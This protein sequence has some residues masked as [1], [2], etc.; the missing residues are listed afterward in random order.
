MPYTILIAESI[1]LFTGLNT[2]DMEY[3]IK[4]MIAK[5]QKVELLVELT[6]K[7]KGPHLRKPLFLLNRGDVIR[8][9]DFYV[10]NVALYQAEPHPGA[11]FSDL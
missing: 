3:S 9:R 1:Y 11:A 6:Y 2:P 7:N 5:M 8:T 4:E 10:P